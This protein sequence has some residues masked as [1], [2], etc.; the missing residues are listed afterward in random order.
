MDKDGEVVGVEMFDDAAESV[1]FAR[2]DQLVAR[3][4]YPAVEVWDHTEMIYRAERQ[5]KRRSR[6]R[7]KHPI[8]P[9]FTSDE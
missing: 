3:H 4:S 1:A 2:A 6:T 5:S 8:H 9:R 7:S